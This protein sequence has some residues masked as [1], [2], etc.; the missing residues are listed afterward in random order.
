M[1]KKTKNLVN[2]I[3]LKDLSFHDRSAHRFEFST[4]SIH[5]ETIRIDNINIIDGHKSIKS[6]RQYGL[7]NSKMA[8]NVLIKIFRLLK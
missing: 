6:T 3:D 5:N 4:N 8:R 7:T 2:S 1:A